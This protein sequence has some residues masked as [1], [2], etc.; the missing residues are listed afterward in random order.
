MIVPMK[1]LTLLCLHKDREATLEALERLG[2]V[3]V[4]P[5]RPPAGEEVDEAR[6][7]VARAERAVDVLARAAKAAAESKKASPRR[8]AHPQPEDGQAVVERVHELLRRRKELDDE[9]ETL[10][11]RLRRMEP[12]GDFDPAQIQEL[13]ASAISVFLAEA[14]PE[15]KLV[16]PEGVMVQQLGRDRMAQYLVIIAMGKVRLEE[17]DFGAPITEVRLP[18]RPPSEWRARLGEIE[19]ENAE[20][21][22]ELVALSALLPRV[23]SALAEAQELLDFQLV[24]QGMGQEAVVCYLQGYVP[25]ET[26]PLLREAAREHGWGVV[27]ENPR[28]GEP[29]PTLLRYNRFVRPILAV[30]R[31]LGIYPGYEEADIGWTFLVFFSLFFAMLIG[32][33]GYGLLLLIVTILLATKFRHKVPD[34]VRGMVAIVSFTTLIWGIL[35]G[36]WL[37]LP[38]I[39][40]ALANLSIPWLRERDNLI[41][42]CFLIGAIHLT[43]AHIWNALT[44]SPKTKALAELGWMCVVWTMFFLAGNLVIGRPLPS[45]MLYVFAAG[46]VLVILFMAT[47]REL[48]SEWINHALLPLTI[49]GNFVDVV[50]YVRLFAV[51]FASVAVIQSFNSMASAIGFDRPFTAVMAVLI[52]IFAH[53]LNLVL[54][55]LAVLVHAVRL[56]TLEFSTHKGITWQGFLYKPFARRQTQPLEEEAAKTS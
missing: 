23:R 30:L 42:L 55:A 14:A 2:V 32:D 34:Y 17:L 6:N 46:V 25:A 38:N 56:N 37:G 52:L 18:E 48:K 35:S 53:S 45:F 27:L 54:G 8:K 7:R 50:S 43:I 13:A 19:K 40:Q 9:A 26:E 41:W 21:E 4:V 12:F 5:V 3:H 51:G 16:A 24:R 22:D 31:F 11:S 44:V 36:N 1:R 20:I 49:I 10:R 29:V 33:A 39:P 15:A 28:P 47:P